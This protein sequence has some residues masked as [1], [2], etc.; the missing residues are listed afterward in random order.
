MS[1]EMDA[2]KS[3]VTGLQSEV[4]RAVEAINRLSA[5]KEDTAGLQQV[6][7]ALTDAT[8]L[9]KASV[10]ANAPTPEPTPTPPPPTE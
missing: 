9:L 8:A 7:T 1:Q 6:A 5:N 3:A 2:V 10:D 4:V